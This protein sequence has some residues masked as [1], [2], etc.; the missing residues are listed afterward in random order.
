MAIA[1][2]NSGASVL[3]TYIAVGPSAPPIIPIEAA[4]ST[5]NPIAGIAAPNA[6]APRKVINTPNCAAAPKRMLLGLAISGPKSVIIPIPRKIRG[7]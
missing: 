4:C 1:G 2:S 6:R 3:V 5:P 7:G